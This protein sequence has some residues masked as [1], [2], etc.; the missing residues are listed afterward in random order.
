MPARMV[1]GLTVDVAAAAGDEDAAGE[2]AVARVDATAEDDRGRSVGRAVAGVASGELAAA[3]DVRAL[4]G[5]GSVGR[6]EATDVHPV[7]TDMRRVRTASRSTMVES[8]TPRQVEP[9]PSGTSS[10][11]RRVRSKDRLRSSPE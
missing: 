2:A 1:A 8:S 7:E 11:S 5:G 4:E 9:S 6:P 3:E 10:K